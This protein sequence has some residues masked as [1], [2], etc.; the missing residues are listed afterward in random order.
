MSKKK[1]VAEEVDQDVE[2][3][4][5]VEVK[6]VCD[7]DVENLLFLNGTRGKYFIAY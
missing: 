1:I 5:V 3:N 6:V 4:S 2:E 7:E